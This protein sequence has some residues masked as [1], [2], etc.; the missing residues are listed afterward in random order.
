MMARKH[1]LVPTPILPILILLSLSL[2]L[3]I[4]TLACAAQTFH[5]FDSQQSSNPWLLPIWLAH[6]DLRGL[7]VVLAAST[8]ILLLDC[9]AAIVLGVKVSGITR[10]D[11]ISPT[12]SPAFMSLD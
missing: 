1:S 9:A 4:T 7:R 12:L 10:R 2:V 3:S 11:P 5:L 8:A 6:F